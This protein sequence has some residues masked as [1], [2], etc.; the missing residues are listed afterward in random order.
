M[1]PVFDGLPNIYPNTFRFVASRL[2]Q[3]LSCET[4]CR[5]LLI[6]PSPQSILLVMLGIQIP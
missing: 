1:F 5:P 2:T 4:R 3:V 6:F